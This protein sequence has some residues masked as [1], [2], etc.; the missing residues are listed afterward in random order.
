MWKKATQKVTMTGVPFFG[1]NTD[2]VSGGGSKFVSRFSC[3]LRR[4]GVFSNRPR[5]NGGVGGSVDQD[6][7][8]RRPIARV[9]IEK[10]GHVSL[11]LDGADFVHLQ[12]S[13]RFV[14]QSIY[15]DAMADVESPDLCLASGVFYVIGAA[16]FEGRPMKREAPGNQIT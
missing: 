12:S 14:R 16:Q 10:Q 7:A 5:A 3:D 15:V 2:F 8:A 6:E 11:E 1:H 13:A 4:G 9:R